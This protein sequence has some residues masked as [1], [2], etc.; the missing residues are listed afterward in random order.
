[1]K[2]YL[3]IFKVLKTNKLNIFIVV[4]TAGILVGCKNEASKQESDLPAVTSHRIV[5]LQ[6][7]LTEIVAGLGYQDQIVGV[8]V[9]STFPETVKNTAQDLG[10]VRSVTIES[11]LELQPTMILATDRDL[12]QDLQQKIESSGVPLHIFSQD[13][14]LEGTKSLIQEVAVV[15]G[16]THYELLLQTIDQDYSQVVVQEPR[17]KVLFI[18]A[19]GAGT[20]MVAGNHTPMKSIVELAGGQYA[21]TEF[22]DFKPLTPESLIASNPDV[23]LFFDSGLQSLGGVDGVLQIKGVAE[24][25]AG[26]NRKIISLEGGF[27][28]GFGPRVGSAAAQLNERINE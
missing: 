24:T 25:N 4:F 17:P 1:M 23:L 22:D 12:N 18:Y 21:I 14:S 6:G 10:H 28:S 16:T 19:R 13:Y 15:L 9:T 11:I 5:S 26:K 8:D 27:L 7:A 20:L 3:K 2:N